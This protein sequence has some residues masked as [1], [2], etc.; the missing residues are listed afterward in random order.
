VCR[1]WLHTIDVELTGAA[2]PTV[3]EGVASTTTVVSHAAAT[4]NGNSEDA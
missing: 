4:A 3:A 2:T 1:S